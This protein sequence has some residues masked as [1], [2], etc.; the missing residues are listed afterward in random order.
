[1]G[2]TQGVTSDTA[3]QNTPWRMNASKP[4]PFSCSDGP[5]LTTICV[6]FSPLRDLTLSGTG[7]GGS[8][9]IV[10]GTVNECV[11]Q[12]QPC[13]SQTCTFTENASSTLPGAAS[14]LIRTS[15]VQVNGFLCSRRTSSPS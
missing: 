15:W 14:G 5:A 8:V 12:V 6:F 1:M 10:T 4:V 13:S 9:L 11:P 2:K 7:A 3:P